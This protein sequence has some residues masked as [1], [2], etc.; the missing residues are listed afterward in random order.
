MLI[1]SRLE[2]HKEIFHK[3]C[4]EC[5]ICSLLIQDHVMA[6]HMTGHSKELGEEDASQTTHRGPV[7]DIEFTCRECNMSFE[8]E[9][10]LSYHKLVHQVSW[11]IE[12]VYVESLGADS[13]IPLTQ[14]FHIS[15]V[16]T[17]IP[18]IQVFHFG[19]PGVGTS[20]LVPHIQVFHIFPHFV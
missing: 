10:H 4:T 12:H 1:T 2:R 13:F 15:R 11:S 16:S 20:T 19:L 18:H 3:N 9:E 7:K 8:S 14:V 17:F 5:P 6:V